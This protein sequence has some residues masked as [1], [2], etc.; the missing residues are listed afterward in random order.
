MTTDRGKRVKN[1][2][3]Q[4]PN[5]K[6][7]SNHKS[8]IPNRAFFSFVIS[9]IGFWDLLFGAWDLGFILSLMPL[10]FFHNE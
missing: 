1:N 9:V 5:I 2:K 6:Q 3:L 8:Q 4:I 10:F 7:I